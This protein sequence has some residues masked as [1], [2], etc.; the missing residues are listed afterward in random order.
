MGEADDPGAEARERMVRDQIERRGLREAGLTRALRK[1]PRHRFMPESRSGQAYGDHPAPIGSGQTISQPYIVALMTDELKLRGTERVLEL[2]TGSGYQTAVLAELCAEVFTVERL[3]E[4]AERARVLLG[5]LG[6]TNVRFRTGDGTLGWPE[7][8]PFGGILVTA[9]APR[10]PRPLLDQL[11]E[12]GR[13]VVPVG[14]R[15]VQDLAVVEK[16]AGG[17]L[18]ELSAGGCRFVP[19]IGEH[20]WNE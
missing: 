1:V 15:Y 12:G 14:D 4:L 10:L 16:Q 5:E 13:L 6:Y 8:A 11:G 9:G 18:R 19:L 7:E 20:G 17:K 3:P 2:G